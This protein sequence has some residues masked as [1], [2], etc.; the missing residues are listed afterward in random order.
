MAW[1]AWEAFKIHFISDTGRVTSNDENGGQ[2]YSEAQAYALF[3]ALA[4]NDRAAFDTLLQWTEN[5][6]CAG[7][8]TTRLPAWL[9]GKKPDSSWGVVDSNPASDAD[10]WIAYALGE[11][12]RLWDVR[13]YRALSALLAARAL[14]EETTDLPGL[15]LSLLPAPVGF[16]EGSGRWR[17]NPSYL[18][19]PVMHWLAAR[20]PESAW[21]VVAGTSLQIILRSAP[22]GFSPDWTVYDVEKGFTV[23]GDGL[24]GQGAYNAIRVYTWAGMMHPDAIGRRALLAKFAPMAVFVRDQGFVPESI[25]IFSAQASGPGPSGFSAAVLPFL[26]AR[27]EQAALQVQRQRLVAQPLR[28]D[29]YYEQVLGL[30]GLGWMEGRFQFAATGHLMPRWNP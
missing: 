25:D 2:T 1:P 20:E 5:N 4:A 6:L 12:G 23:Y 14:R 11:A 24:K 15:G 30:F 17:L 3:F 7:D 18:P 10:L 27:D 29:A 26:Q 22:Q 28:P 13:R 21:G 19:L 8:M 9:W 16:E